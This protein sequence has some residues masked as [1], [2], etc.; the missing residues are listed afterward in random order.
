VQLAGRSRRRALRRR[1]S[2]SG[3]RGP[4]LFPAAPAERSR[5]GRMR[6]RCLARRGLLAHCPFC[7]RAS[8]SYRPRPGAL[9]RAGTRS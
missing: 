4:V 1:A 6:R 8:P 7:S 5:V 9:R 2:R 3:A